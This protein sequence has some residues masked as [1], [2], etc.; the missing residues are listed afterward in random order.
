VGEGAEGRRGLWGYFGSE[1][2]AGG[3][4]GCFVPE[5]FVACQC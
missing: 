3:R 5:A 1:E 2:G 4:E